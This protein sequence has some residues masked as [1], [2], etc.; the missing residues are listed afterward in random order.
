MRRTRLALAVIALT[1]AAWILAGCCGLL[2][3]GTTSGGSESQKGASGGTATLDEFFGARTKQGTFTITTQAYDGATDTE[4]AEFWVEE[5]RFRIDYSNG[6]TLRMS[7]RCVDGKTAY[8]CDPKKKTARP[9]V[10]LPEVYLR[11]FTKPEAVGESLGTDPKTG[12][13]RIKYVVKQTSN[14]PGAENAWYVE[15]LVYSVKGDRLLSVV[16][17]SG[18]PHEGEETKLDTHTTVFT[19]L[20]TGKPIPA[21]TF[22]LPY[23]VVT[24]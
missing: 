23:P 2:P 17:R 13:E 21:E 18:V 22:E 24:K 1:G 14:V 10:A 20:V 15:D 12:A 6:G 8:F 19:K 7:I 11:K 9:S 16:D 5:G 4:E 3:T